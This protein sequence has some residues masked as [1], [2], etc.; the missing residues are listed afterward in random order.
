MEK[1]TLRVEMGFTQSLYIKGRS[2]FLLKCVVFVLILLLYHNA[3]LYK[4]LKC[5]IGYTVTIVRL[6]NVPRWTL[7]AKRLIYWA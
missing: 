4:A 1:I 2:K 3:I 7:M 6:L 5:K